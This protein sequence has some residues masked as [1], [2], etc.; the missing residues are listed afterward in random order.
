MAET[1]RLPVCRVADFARWRELARAL[2]IAGVT[3]GE[4]HWSDAS[5]GEPSLFDDEGM[6]LAA[7]RPARPAPRV[8]TGL[9]DMLGLAA[10]HDAAE[11]WALLYRVLWRWTEGERACLNAGD[12]DGARL[13]QMVRAVRREIHHVH[14]FVRFREQ[15]GDDADTP[16]FVA[17]Y[18]PAYPVL[19]HAAPFFANRM[20]RLSWLIATPRECVASD[21]ST[22]RFGP[23]LAEPPAATADAQEALWIAYYRNT[24]NPARLNVD[25]MRGHMPVRLWKNLPEAAEIDALVGAATSGASRV[26]QSPEVLRRARRRGGAGT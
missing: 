14:A 19:R 12:E 22:L 18:E 4:V 15:A 26:A 16:R 17:W 2:L 8:P 11:R 13:Q 21:G 10:C 5:G 24:F 1:A 3:P 23:G 25:L 6:A 20:G 9:L 7:L